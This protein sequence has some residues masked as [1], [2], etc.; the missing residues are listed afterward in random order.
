MSKVVPFVTQ[1]QAEEQATIWIS[2]LDRGLSDQEKS[3]LSEWAHASELNRQTLLGLS[4]VWDEMDRLRQ[5]GD[6]FPIS[7]RA[8][9]PHSLN[10]FQGR[11]ALV[12]GLAFATAIFFMV[13]VFEPL[14]YFSDPDSL[15][16]LSYQTAIG[17]QSIVNLPDASQITLN[18]NSEVEVVYNQYERQIT[19]LHGEAH[20]DVTHDTDRPFFVNAGSKVVR[21]VGTAFNVEVYDQN[22]IEVVVDDGRVVVS[23]SS[24][25]VQTDEAEVGLLIKEEQYS[26]AKGERIILSDNTAKTEVQLVS[27]TEMSDRLSWKRGKLVFRGKPLSEVLLEIERYTQVKIE[28]ADDELKPTL[29]AGIFQAGDVEGLLVSL[30]ENFDIGHTWMRPNHILLEQLNTDFLN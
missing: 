30:E 8:T 22:R 28:M 1:R 21:A 9:E 17:E 11:K 12:S 25:P 5:L 27:D 3:E 29:I 24:I 2:R 14:S 7:D 10:F 23:R 20:F 18:T 26:V 19:L 4:Q 15:I 6:L 13:M 16:R